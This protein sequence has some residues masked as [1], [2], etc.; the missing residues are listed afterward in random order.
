MA[1][2]ANGQIVSLVGGGLTVGLIIGISD[3]LDMSSSLCSYSVVSTILM[4][5]S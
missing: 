2:H 1:G 5:N 3:T 4:T